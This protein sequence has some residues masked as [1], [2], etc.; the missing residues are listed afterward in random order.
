M[1]SFDAPPSKKQY[2]IIND[3]KCTI[4][5]DSGAFSV[6]KKGKEINIYDYIEYIKKNNIDIYF[7]LDVIGNTED[8]MKNQKTMEEHGLNPIPVFHY[9]EDFTHLKS[10]VE[11]GYE[12][13]GLGGTVGKSIPKRMEF[14]DKCFEL[15]PNVGF[16][17]LGV[18]SKLLLDRYNWKSVDSTTWLVP[19]KN[20][21]E[22]TIEGNQI[23][24]EEKD[25]NKRFLNSLEYFNKLKSREV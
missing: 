5:L 11:S 19:F 18:T 10:L 25:P 15:Y 3:N 13:I 16:H 20:G 2:K 9:G 7:N 17:G 23:Q 14:F 8:T 6:W 12:Y 22:I 1:W 24:S 4:M 21:K